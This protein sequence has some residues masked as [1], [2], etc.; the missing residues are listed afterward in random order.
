[1][2]V[3]KH[4]YQESR[5][6]KYFNVQVEVPYWAQYLAADADGELWAYELE[7]RFFGS[8]WMEDDENE[9]GS[10]KI[11]MLDLGVVNW[12]YTLVDVDDICLE[13]IKHVKN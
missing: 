5:T 4:I 6:V 2:I 12:K 10:V 8:Y 9:S 13:Y 7:P 1:M 3:E 11:A